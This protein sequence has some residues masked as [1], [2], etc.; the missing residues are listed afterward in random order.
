M[1]ALA[2]NPSS[3]CNSGLADTASGA[4]DTTFFF[5]WNRLS[6]V[7]NNGTNSADMYDAVQSLKIEGSKAGQGVR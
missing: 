7:L 3:L 1:F 6:F 5:G 2:Y 4:A